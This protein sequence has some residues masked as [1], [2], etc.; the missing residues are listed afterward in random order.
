MGV[1]SHLF[2]PRYR[3][4]SSTNQFAQLRTNAIRLLRGRVALPHLFFA[5]GSVGPFLIFPQRG[6]C[7]FPTRLAVCYGSELS[8]I[9]FDGAGDS[10]RAPVAVTLLVFI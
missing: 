1:W 8:P 2:D 7:L 6:S 4:C 9:H 3:A 10:S 5:I